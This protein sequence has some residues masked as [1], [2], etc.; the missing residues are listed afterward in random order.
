M[1]ERLPVG[2]PEKMKR[3]PWT[4][5]GEEGDSTRYPTAA[6]AWDRVKVFTGKASAL[7]KVF[8]NEL[9]ALTVYQVNWWPY[10]DREWGFELNAMCS[11]DRLAW[12]CIVPM[13]CVYAVKWHIPH[14]H[15]PPTPVASTFTGRVGSIVSR[16]QTGDRSTRIT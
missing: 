10:H 11:K 2:R 5:Y 9:D 3:R 7:Y 1:W 4:E 14:R 15:A 16:S 12:R 8:T 13:I 6:Y